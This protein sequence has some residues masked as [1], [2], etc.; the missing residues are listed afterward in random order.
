MAVKLKPLPRKKRILNRGYLYSRAD[1]K[2]KS[3]SVTLMDM[4]SAILNYFEVYI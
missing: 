2:V 1:D 4:D 3:P